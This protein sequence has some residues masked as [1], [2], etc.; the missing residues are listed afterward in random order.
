MTIISVNS[1]SQLTSALSKAQNGDVIQLA[2]GNYSNVVLSNIKTNGNV[3]I[4]SADP[5]KQAVLSDL[6]VKGSSGLTFKNLDLSNTVPGKDFAFQVLGSS[7]IVLDHLKVHGP[8]NIGSGQEVAL[9]MV[10]SSSAVTVKDSEFFNGY[11]GISMLDNKGLTIA[12]NYVHDL[13][14]DGVRGGGN[15]N[16]TITQNTFT[17]FHPA[18]LDH[19]D[20]IQLWTNNTTASATNINITDNLVVRGNGA[21]IQGI[22]MRDIIGNL[23]FKNLN[24]TGNMIVG[25]RYNGISVEHADGATIANNTV[26]G[27]VGEQSWIRTNNSANV[28]VSNNQSTAFVAQQQNMPG[29]N[30]NSTINPVFDLGTSYVTGWLASHTGFSGHWAGSDSLWMQSL[31]LNAATLAAATALRAQIATINGG[32]GD[33]RLFASATSDSVVNGGTGNDSIDGGKYFTHQL[34]GGSGDDTYFIRSQTATVVEAA[35]G[36]LDTVRTFVDYTLTS[37]VENLRLE[38]GGLTGV[39]NALG[40]LII[41]SGGDD[42]IYGMG[43]NDNIQGRDGNDEIWGGTGLDTIRGEN[44]NDLLYGEQGDDKIDG[45]AGNDILDGGDGNDLILGGA[46]SDV[47]KGGAGSDIFRFYAADVTTFT[48]DQITDFTSGQDKIDLKQIYPGGGRFTFIGTQAFHNVVGEL[49]YSVVNGSALIEGDING[50]G[51]ADFAIK[52]DAVTKLSAS[53]FVI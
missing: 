28:T 12:N 31:G 27:Y 5:L 42:M 34:N 52:L 18:P 38:T 48:A 39:G 20:A 50:D 29:V 1:V 8:N 30:G 26:A 25:A 14:M 7:N 17:N 23:P 11:T 2:A 9:M 3:T 45:G 24:I 6:M 16:L 49:H 40:N 19:P 47:M 46:G 13:R 32:I 22:F 53:D 10:R 37:E 43:G 36:G 41:G 35:N 21:P 33:D 15:S 44:G 4:T 51:K